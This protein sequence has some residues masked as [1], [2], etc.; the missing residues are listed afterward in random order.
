M[1]DE[2]NYGATHARAELTALRQALA[3]ANSLAETQ[4]KLIAVQ[5]Q[6]IDTLKETVRLLELRAG[7]AP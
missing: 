1:T 5:E 4:A 7:G 2:M 6:M 3:Q